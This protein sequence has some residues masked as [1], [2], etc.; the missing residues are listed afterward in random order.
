MVMAT[1][2][3][4]IACQ[5]LDKPWLAACLTWLNLAV[6]LVLWL[7]TLARVLLFGRKLLADLADHR[8][9]MGL[10]TAAA[11]TCVLGNQFIVV[12][13]HCWIAMS[14]WLV[15]V[16][17][18]A[19]LTYAV[20]TAYTIKEGKPSLAEGIDGGWLVAVV[21]TQDVSNLGGLLVPHFATHRE[22]I[23]FACLSWWL[24]G[25]ML[26]IWL[27]ALIFYRYTFFELTPPDL[28]PTYWI[29]M[30]AMAIPTLAGTT[31]LERGGDS[32]LVQDLAPFIKGCAILCW[33]TA[34]WWIPMLVILAVWRHVYKRLRLAYDPLYWGAV[35]P[36]GMY[37]VCTF[38]LS[39]VTHQPFLAETARW[40]IYVA[41]AAWLATFIG[42]A[43][44]LSRRL[45]E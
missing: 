39:E 26:Y 19:G 12:I 16:V 45:A 3:V 42:L 34:T 4:A 38:R 22:L 29:N 24:F 20:F 10:F 14:L 5:L 9:G 40:F 41:L 1:G 37:T 17:R 18:W 28:V 23:L 44:G 6:F 25:V 33:A 15:G 43:H 31:L 27:I 30:G 32:E 2:I 11:G 21:A 36:L 35:F 8:R 13:A 7:M